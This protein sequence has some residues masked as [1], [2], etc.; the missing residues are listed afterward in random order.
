MYGI[1]TP[2]CRTRNKE[3]KIKGLA[4]KKRLSELCEGSL[5]IKSHGIGKYGRVLGEVYNQ[6]SSLG[7]ML[8]QEGHAK[9]YYGGRR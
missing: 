8:I 9:E 5:I 6:E 1:N 3:E 4:A 2:E 7:D